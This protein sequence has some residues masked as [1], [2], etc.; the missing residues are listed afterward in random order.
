MT[1]P[2][3]LGAILAIV[4]LIIALLA[5][6]GIALPAQIIWVCVALLAVARLT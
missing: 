1:I 3:G 2:T 6:I 5:I 4:A